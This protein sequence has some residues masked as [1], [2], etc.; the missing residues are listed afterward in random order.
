LIAFSYYLKGDTKK[1]SDAFKKAMKLQDQSAYLNNEVL[2]KTTSNTNEMMSMVKWPVDTNEK[3]FGKKV[4]EFFKSYRPSQ[5]NRLDPYHQKF[6]VWSEKKTEGTIFTFRALFSQTVYRDMF[7]FEIEEGYK[8]S[9]QVQLGSTVSQVEKAYGNPYF[10]NTS[11]SADQYLYPSQSMIV[12]IDP[13]SG[14]VTGIMY[15]GTK[16]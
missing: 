5:E 8:T 14:T 9:G 11:A 15:Y 4:N 1:M 3:I 12:T 10:I 13:V 7:F 6:I 16:K 2:T